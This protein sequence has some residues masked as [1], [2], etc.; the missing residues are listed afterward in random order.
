MRRAAPTS[1]T[2]RTARCCWGKDRQSPVT[3]M[4]LML[5]GDT[6]PQKSMWAE[7][8]NQDQDGEDDGIGP[9]GG[10]DLVAPGGEEA[11]HKSSKRRSRHVADPSQH[12]GGERPQSCLVAHPP[13]ADVVVEALDHARS[14]GQRAAD[15]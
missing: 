14:A 2:V 10:D 1:A 12:S 7:H 13:L 11:D 8:E 6:F 9:P 5:L 15:E 4:S 3:D